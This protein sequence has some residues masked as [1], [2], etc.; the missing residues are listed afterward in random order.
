MM[1]NDA[2][3]RFRPMGIADILDESFDLY[4]T[5]FVMLI[6]IAAVM[7]VPSFLIYG[8]LDSTRAQDPKDP[9][10]ALTALGPVILMGF[11]LLA[12]IQPFITA[13][14]TY[15]ISERYVG[16]TVT[17]ESAYKRIAKTSVLLPFFGAIALK[18]LALMGAYFGI[19]AAVALPVVVV[20]LA[21]PVLAALI[22]LILGVPGVVLLLRVYLGLTLVEPAV[23]IEGQGA[24]AA[25]SRSWDLMKGYALKGFWLLLII[26]IALFFIQAAL[27]GTTKTIIMMKQFSGQE[28]SAGIVWLD[29]ILDAVLSTLTMPIASIVMILLYYDIRM[30]KEGF[31]LVLLA[32]ELD[33]TS[34]AQSFTTLPLPQEQAKPEEGGSQGA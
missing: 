23:I 13:V 16:R 31:D 17:I 19:L 24:G 14:L 5:D 9:M 28:A 27:T 3:R 30:R 21:A 22:G 33:T 10:A 4:K 11:L 2:K 32:R 1:N 18:W 29:R 12:V 26:G 34:R 7:Y 6:G 20:G 25:L 8:M 15:A